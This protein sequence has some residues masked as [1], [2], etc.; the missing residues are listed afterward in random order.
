MFTG[1]VETKG[2]IKKIEKDRSNKIFTIESSISSALRID[3]SVSHDGVC[4]TV[5]DVKGD[6]HRVEAIQETLQRSILGDNSVGT[7]INLERSMLASGR[8]DGHLVQGHVDTKA[9]CHSVEEADGSWYFTFTYDRSFDHL[10]VQKG[11]ICVN[12]V[13]LT[14]VD[15]E[16]GVFNVA[17]IP[18]T[19]EHTNFQDIV[20]GDR[21]NIEFDILGKYVSRYL[22]TIQNK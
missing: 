12:G 11:S 13:S 17:I 8:L 19:M 3:Q 10:V 15:P 1:I 16:P 9:V 22:S 7:Q 6:Q 21:V 4:L 2:I 14:V 5:V 20:K 18:Y